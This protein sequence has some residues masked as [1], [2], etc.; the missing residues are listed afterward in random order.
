MAARLTKYLTENEYL[1]VSVQ[2][3]GIPGV[4]G[5]I[6]HATMTWETIQI[7]KSDKKRHRCG[8]ARSGQCIWISPTQDDSTG[9]RD[10]P[11]PKE[12]LRNA[13]EVLSWL[14]NAVLH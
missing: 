14:L 10:V 5:C 8:V 2:K 12:H 13:E 11:C 1:N 6:E 9:S 4:L 3:G 7:A